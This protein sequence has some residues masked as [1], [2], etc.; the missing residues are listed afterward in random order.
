[1]LG[2]LLVGLF[3]IF[4]TT[5]VALI[6][7]N[8]KTQKNDK[9]AFEGNEKDTRFKYDIYNPKEDFISNYERYFYNI[10]K[11]IATENNLIVHPQLNLASIIEKPKSNLQKSRTNNALF[12]NIDFAFFT[13]DYRELLLLVEINDRTHLRK[14]RK[15]RDQKVIN[16][17]KTVGIKLIHFYSTSNDNSK[18]HVKYVILKVL[19]ENNPNF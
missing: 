18:E 8:G 4:I 17:C 11:E 13:E 5:I 1:M 2:F 6:G 16:I 7:G 14:D 12:R 15:E 10:F 9:N 3:L 19:K